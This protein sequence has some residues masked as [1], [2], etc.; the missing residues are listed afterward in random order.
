MI[1]PQWLKKREQEYKK[2]TQAKKKQEK[3]DALAAEQMLKKA[4]NEKMSKRTIKKM[5]W[6]SM[7]RSQKVKI[8]KE[9]K[10][11]IIP[12][13]VQMRLRYLGDL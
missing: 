7:A 11:E 1:D 2:Q 10:V 3:D 13:D 12:E 9:K 4:E 6:P 5:G 8:T